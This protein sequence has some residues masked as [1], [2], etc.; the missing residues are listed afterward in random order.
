MFRHCLALLLEWHTGLGSHQA[1]S[2]AEAQ[3]I[4]NGAKDKPA[5]VVVDVDMSNGDGIELI[6]Q[7]HGL[8]VL[9]LMAGRSLERRAQALAAGADEG[10]PLSVPADRIVD[11]VKRL[12][13]G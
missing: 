9:A 2:L 5:C 8:P 1:A 10:L 13:G 3:R 11:T 7:L 4:L 6:Q 12:V